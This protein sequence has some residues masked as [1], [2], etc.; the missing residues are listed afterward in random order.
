[1]RICAFGDSFVNG[2]GD[3]EAL[4]WV[5]RAVQPRKRHDRE[6]TLYN[7]GIR[8]D[9]SADIRR[10]WRAEAEARRMAG[11]DFALLFAFGVNDCVL[12]GESGRTR[13]AAEASR[14]N[15][16][17]MLGEATALGRVLMVGPPPIA[18]DGVNARVGALDSGFAGVAAA[19]GVPYLPVFAALRADPTWMAEVARWDGAHPGAD[20]YAALAALVGG[21]DAWR[22]WFV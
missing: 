9:T 16:A 22:E 2:T 3:P 5:G 6:V 14:D 4:G 12:D 21:W 10:R 15:A 19:A 11:M 18:D 20:G 1:M 13:V 17:A 8:R 7:L